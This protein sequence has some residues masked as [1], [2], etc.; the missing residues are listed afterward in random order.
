[1]IARPDGRYLVSV[2]MQADLYMQLRAA[3]LEL[4]QPLTVWCREAIKAQLARQSEEIIH[5]PT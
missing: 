1:M 3:C 5:T 4:D 2:T